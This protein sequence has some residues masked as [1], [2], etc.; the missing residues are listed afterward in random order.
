VRVWK[1]GVG[2]G[3]WQ[4]DEVDRYHQ[5]E[6]AA[7]ASC[8][9]HQHLGTALERSRLK[10]AAHLGEAPIGAGG[11]EDLVQQQLAVRVHHAVALVSLHHP[12]SVPVRA[13]CEEGAKRRVCGGER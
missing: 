7:G 11:L 4:L 2:L 5:Q 10:A 1:T 6:R 8:V 12:T 3:F 9:L 13:E